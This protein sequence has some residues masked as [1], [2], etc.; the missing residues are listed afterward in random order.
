M[1]VHNQR[2]ADKR[3]LEYETKNASVQCLRPLPMRH[4][5]LLNLGRQ[6][7]PA[8][9]FYAEAPSQLMARG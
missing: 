1:S 7:T 4:E 8:C 5:P 3:A 6:A 2:V 9:S